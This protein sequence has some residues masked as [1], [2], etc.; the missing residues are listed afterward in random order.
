MRP[1]DYVAAQDTKAALQKLA[2]RSADAVPIG[3][4]TNLVDLMKIHVQNPAVLVDINGLPLAEIQE[5][6]GGLRIG[7]L[8]RNSDPR[9]A[10]RPPRRRR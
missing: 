4:G 6:D 7:A 9:C 3:G 5:V 10:S 2:S 1:I 8:V